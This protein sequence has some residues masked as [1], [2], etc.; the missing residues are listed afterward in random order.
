MSSFIKRRP[1]LVFYLLAFLISWLGYVPA[2]LYSR[3]LSPFNSP[4]LVVLGGGGPAI[5][6]LIVASIL[7]RGKGLRDLLAPLLR[8]RV[9]IGWYLVALFLPPALFAL[10]ALLGAPFGLPAFDW[11]K[12]GPPFVPVIMLLSY[13]L[14]NVW[15]E[16]GW[17]GFAL[18]RLQ[19]KRSAL[20]SSLIVGL[21]W[22]LWHAP[23]FFIE[24]NPMSE[25]PLLYWFIGNLAVTVVYTWVYN[26]AR[27]SL[28]LATLLHAAQNTAAAVL[29]TALGQFP[30]VVVVVDAALKCLL[31]AVL[32]LIYRPAHLAR[33]ERVS[34][35]S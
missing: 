26:G 22:C 21:L 2:A 25:M 3:G 23:L 11:S 4:L 33:G 27:G 24:D 31:A 16:I 17:R 30:P 8:W 12:V 13:M 29:Y 10:A 9:G 20:V 18:P 34:V 35:V 5:A 1:V 6:A 15:E 32:I 19:A 14:V 7:G 28:L